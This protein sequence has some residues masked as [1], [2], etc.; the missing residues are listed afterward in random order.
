MTMPTAS[1]AFPNTSTLFATTHGS[2]SWTSGRA[3]TL[4][5]ADV[6]MTLDP[7]EI[8]SVY[9]AARSLAADVY[10]CESACRWQLRV[11]DRP[12]LVLD[13]DEVLQ[14]DTLL[15][16]AVAMLDLDAMLRDARVTWAE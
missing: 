1:P 3:L 4:S 7:S 16:G 10:R 2:V 8:R 13:S 6:E 15:D 9:R 12:V 11:P 5:L 14:L